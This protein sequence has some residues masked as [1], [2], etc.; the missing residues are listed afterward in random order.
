LAAKDFNKGANV[1]TEKSERPSCVTVNTSGAPVLGL[2][3]GIRGG[4][5]MLPMILLIVIDGL[6]ISNTTTAGST[7]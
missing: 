2:K 5:L 4:A 3:L 6:P 1:T 7:F